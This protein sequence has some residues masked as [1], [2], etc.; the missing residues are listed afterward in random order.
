MSGPS[1]FTVDG[2]DGHLSAESVG[3][4]GRDGNLSRQ[5]TDTHWWSDGSSPSIST[6]GSGCSIGEEG[7]GSRS[8][9]ER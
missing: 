4:T 6:A 5:T 9:S 7:D 3:T 8:F 1:R 2:L